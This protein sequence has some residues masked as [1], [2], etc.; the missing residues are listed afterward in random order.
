MSQCSG[1]S[2]PDA[3]GW[4]S[5]ENTLICSHAGGRKPPTQA[6]ARLFCP[7]RVGTT[8]PESPCG[9]PVHLCSCFLGRAP[10]TWV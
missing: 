2:T 8:F 10:V 9:F 6:W 5:D 3:T 7:W 4:G 1:A